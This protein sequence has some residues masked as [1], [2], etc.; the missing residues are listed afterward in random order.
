VKTTI[1][2]LLPFFLLIAASCS[3]HSN[4]MTETGAEV[5]IAA[6][7]GSFS[8]VYQVLSSNN[9]V[10][11]HSPG[12]AAHD[13]SGVEL[14]LSSQA[15]AYQALTSASVSG[16]SSSGICAGVRIVAPGNPAS[17]YLLG[18]LFS[19]YNTSDFGGVSGCQPYSGH[20]Q[21]TNLTQAEQAS[22]TTWIQNGAPN[23]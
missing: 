20:L 22:L 13:I 2:R 23:N 18:V 12:G 21:D 10:S 4:R 11:C 17:S 19:S 5:D 6:K 7:S 3:Q 16:V 1:K 15:S 9:C 8:G 14:D